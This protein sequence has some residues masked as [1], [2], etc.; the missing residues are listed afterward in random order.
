[1]TRQ[2]KSVSLCISVK[3]V[4]ISYD[5]LGR[6]LVFT[7]DIDSRTIVFIK[8]FYNKSSNKKEIKNEMKHY[9]ASLYS[10]IG[11]QVLVTFYENGVGDHIITQITRDNY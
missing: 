2:K 8:D 10:L 4:S 9:A 1:M 6:V 7:N 11:Q 5:D 3:L